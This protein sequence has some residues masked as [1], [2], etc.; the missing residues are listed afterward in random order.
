MPF[1]DSLQL[2]DGMHG[3]E[4]KRIIDHVQKIL[5]VTAF[6]QRLCDLF[7]LVTVD[8]IHTVSYFFDTADL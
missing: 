3:S 8:E 5:P 6:H 2:T 1:K 7:Q 4:S